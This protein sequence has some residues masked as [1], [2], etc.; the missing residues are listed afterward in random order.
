MKHFIQRTAWPVGAGI[1]SA[2]VIMMAF[3]FANSFFFPLPEGLQLSDKDAV[4]R[5][6]QSL[7]WTAY[8]LVVLGWTFGSF[9]AGCVTTYLA[10]E[11][12][13][14]LSRVVGG[15]LAGLSLL[16]AYMIGQSW[17]FTITTLPIFIGGTYLGHRYL[18]SV[19]C[20]RGM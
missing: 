20:A 5:F 1:L 2:F 16:N 3:E 10:H 11:Q 8:I 14:R 19:H 12:T 9:K 13:Y 18:R 17:L 7:P 15:M 4:A 6:T